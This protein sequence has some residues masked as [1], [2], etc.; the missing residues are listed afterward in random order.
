MPKPIHTMIRVLDEARSLRFYND[1]F[2]LK[3]ADRFD[4]DG[5]SLIYLRNPRSDFELELTVN[6]SSTRPYELGN[7][8]GH[9]A[10]VVDDLVAELCGEPMVRL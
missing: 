1:V 4:F 8:Y 9:M 7:G 10:F 5:F 3:P 6:R 2:D